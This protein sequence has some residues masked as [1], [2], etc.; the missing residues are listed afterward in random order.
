MAH[1][2]TPFQRYDEEFKSLKKQVQDSLHDDDDDEE[3]ASHTS[4]LL[5]QCDEL[6]QQMALEAR[7][8]SDSALKRELLAQVRTYKT[9]VQ[10]LKDDYNK[11]ALLAGAGGSRSGNNHRERLLKQQDMLLNQNSQL[12]NARKVLEETEQ[13]ALEIGT[14]LAHNRETIE[15]AHG[16][17]RTVAGLT[18][19]A[20]RVLSSMSQRQT[21]QKMV[22]YG[23]A[24]GVVVF[25][26]LVLW[27]MRR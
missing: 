11:K 27:W 16:R 3:L 10:K 14:E 19:R 26:L 24:G 20:R 17:V 2:Y 6:L 1:S 5:T 22:L 21:Q 9:E 13:V 18:G 8:V 12:E 15:S 7:S 4:N 23:L 25:F